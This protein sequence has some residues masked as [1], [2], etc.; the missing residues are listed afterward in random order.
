M[1]GRPSNLI[2]MTKGHRTNEEKEY[3]KAVEQ[4]LYTGESFEESAQVKKSK[5]AHAEFKRLERLYAKI[6]YVDALDQQI[7]NRYCLEVANTYRLQ[8]TLSRL[9]GDLTK[10]LE[11]EDRLR[12]YDL[13]NKTMAAMNKNKELLL[14]YEDRLFLNP[15]G[16]IR[17][18]PKT[19]PKEE[20]AS[21]MAA[22][23]QK[24]A[25]AK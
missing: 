2:D 1:G 20:T 4:S 5:I 16:R 10:D 6:A 18:I 15:S 7:I 12:I 22:F 13:I 11:F 21:G 23:L 3:R 25:E 24:R 19:P 17:A 14:K 9:N 8:N